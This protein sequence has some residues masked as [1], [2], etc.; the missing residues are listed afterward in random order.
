MDAVVPKSGQGLEMGMSLP[1][2]IA[3]VLVSQVPCVEPQ[4][5]HLVVGGGRM[6]AQPPLQDPIGP[7]PMK[8]QFLGLLQCP[9]LN[10]GP[11]IAMCC[12]GGS[13]G[14]PGLMVWYTAAHQ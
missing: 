11:G 7:L 3:P 5:Q 12:H 9:K 8:C 4:A 10:P 6:V 13:N 1:T 2:C 14:I